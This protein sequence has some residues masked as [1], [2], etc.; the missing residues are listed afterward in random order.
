MSW[1]A[2]RTDEFDEWWVTLT[3]SEQR[4]VVASVEALQEIGPT[5][6]RPLV[7]SVEGS[8]HSNMKELRVTQ[9]MRIFFAFDPTRVAILLIGGDKAGKTKRFYKQM[10]PKADQIYDAH[11]RSTAKERKGHGKAKQTL[12]RPK[13]RGS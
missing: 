7:D 2:E 9:T 8:R 3:D 10:I 1:S 13:R 11:L 5:A 12:Q 6:G 4:K